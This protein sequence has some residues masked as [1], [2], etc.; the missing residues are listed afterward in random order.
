MIIFQN[1]KFI[2]L[3]WL[4]IVYIFMQ[5]HLSY[6]SKECFVQQGYVLLQILLSFLQDPL[7]EIYEIESM[8]IFYL[9]ILEPPYEKGKVIRDLLSVEYTIDHMAAE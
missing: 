5:L 8:R 2:L 3:D 7:L 4:N 1:V 9:L 6:E